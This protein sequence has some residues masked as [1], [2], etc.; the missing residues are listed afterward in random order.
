[1]AK[2][3]LLVFITLFL[4]V[5]TAFTRQVSVETARVVAQNLIVE[6]S[7]QI[8]FSGIEL[9][10]TETRS[11]T[12]NYYYIFNFSTPVRGFVIISAD[13]IIYPVLA[14]SF[15]G[16]YSLENIPDNLQELLDNYKDQIAY[17]IEKGFSA[18]FENEKAWHQYTSAKINNRRGYR[19]V[20]PLL[21]TKWNQDKYYNT[22]CP[23][24]NAGS[25]GHVYAGCVATSMAQVMKYYNQPTQ[26]SGSKSY[27]H[28]TYGTLSANFGLTTYNWA[29]MPNT[30]SSYN[31]SVA[32]LLYHCGVS[33]E[34]QYGPNGSGAY[35]SD[36]ASALKNYF[37][38]KSSTQYK[39]KSSYTSSSWNS[40]ITNEL[41]NSRPMI[42]RGQGSSGGHAW[43]VD[44]YQGSSNDHFHCNWGWSG[45]YN[46]YFYLSS[47]N[48]GSYSF[49]SYQGAVIGI[50]PNTTTSN[51][52][53]RLY[54]SISVTP[55][56]VE[57][58]GSISVYL[59]IA[60]YGTGDFTGTYLVALY[61]NSGNY[62]T[63]IEE[64]TVDTLHAGYHY[65]NGLTFSKTSLTVSTGTYQI[66][67][68]YKPVGGSYTLLDEG[69]YTNPVTISV[70]SSSQPEGMALYSEI[71]TYP[72]TFIDG[73]SVSVVV[74]IGNFSYTTNFS[75]EISAVLHKTTGEVLEII[76]TKTNFTINSRYYDSLVFTNSDLTAGP[77][78]YLI[79]IQHKPNGGNW[80]ITDEDIYNNPISVII[81]PPPLSPDIYEV[82]DLEADA[83][84][85]QASFTSNHAVVKTTGSKPAQLQRCGLL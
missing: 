45:Y 27:Y 28:T 13:D 64:T 63:D 69:N 40:L 72:D 70:T 12:V 80:T 68:F 67:A 58:N 14:Y 49:N 73:Q 1:M 6:R 66:A 38:Y 65:T 61:D 26:G 36:A 29:G 78:E 42:Y 57:K 15:E 20:S 22:S 76:D 59:D 60:N 83:Y 39:S 46:G 25:D 41:D 48:P 23:S 11:G 71:K 32:T 75:G 44:G 77:G 79:S 19:S 54:S 24:D 56:P 35:V 55:D 16:N 21:T 30:L 9:N 62:V 7:G 10:L 74:K 50:E 47:L 4:F 5:F 18:G 53:L 2:K 3:Y 17:S 85:L 8:Q 31:T 51:Y 43:V 52:D 34:M 33:V 37:G 84:S 82:N 81:A